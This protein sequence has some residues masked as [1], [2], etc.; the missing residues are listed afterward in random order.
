MPM[1]PTAK[2]FESL[3]EQFMQLPDTVVG[4]ILSGEHHVSPRPDPKHAR[5]ASSI[6]GKVMGPFDHGQGGPGGWLILFEPEIHLETN[7]LV[8]DL[9]GW[10]R[11]VLPSLPDEAFFTTATNWVC[12]VLSPRGGGDRSCQE[13]ATLCSIWSQPCMAGGSDR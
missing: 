9:A 2:K 8:P 12:E 3:H 1:A 11:D 6:G 4:E 13:D 10:R 5:A 7:I